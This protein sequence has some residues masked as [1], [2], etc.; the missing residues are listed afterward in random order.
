MPAFVASAGVT[1]RFLEA[2]GV[3][4]RYEPEELRI[5]TTGL[6]FRLTALALAR[7]HGVRLSPE[8]Q[9]QRIDAGY[10]AV[11]PLVVVT[12]RA[13]LPLD[14][15]VFDPAGPR[16]HARAAGRGPPL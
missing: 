15:R 1:N 12:A 5:A 14:L 16:T 11:P 4:T 13:I 2:Y 3:G 6:N 10:A 7:S 9:A 8:T